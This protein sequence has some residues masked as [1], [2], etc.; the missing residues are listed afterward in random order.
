MLKTELTKTLTAIDRT[1]TGFTD[2]SLSDA[3]AITSESPAN[4]VLYHALASPNVTVGSSAFPTLKEIET[5]ENYVF[6][7]QPPSLGSLKVKAGLTGTQHLSVVVFAYEYRPA[8]DTCTRHQAD[9]VFSRTGI[10]RVGT[11]PARYDD[12]RKAAPTARRTCL[13]L[14][15]E[16]LQFDRNG[17]VCDRLGTG[18]NSKNR[19]M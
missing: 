18:S 17:A 3:K 12:R 2:L 1:V 7:V 5:V 6:G 8:R 9:M 19:L 4:S 14:T 10:S 13:A 16:V 11:R 15:A